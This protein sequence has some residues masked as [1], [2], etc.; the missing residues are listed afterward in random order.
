MGGRV[1]AKSVGSV[2]RRRWITLA[3]VAGISAVFP[4]SLHGQGRGGEVVPADRMAALLGAMSRHATD[5]LLAVFPG[6]GDWTYRQTVHM[7]RGQALRVWR[8]PAA[9]TREVVS[10][11]LRRV[12][13]L[14]VH[15]QPIGRLVHQVL[16]RGSEWRRVT[17]TRF[18]PPGASRSSPVFVEW[19]REG[20]RWVVSAVGDEG[21][22]DGVPL[23]A[24]CC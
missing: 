14:D 12:F 4:G 7:M 6:T 8:I 5:S 16:H 3:L 20:E 18:V 1:A 10:S 11:D 17:P 23:P 19:R 9:Q 24:W 22:D 21:F 13:F 15:A 2:R